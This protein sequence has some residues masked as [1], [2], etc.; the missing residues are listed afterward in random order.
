MSSPANL[1]RLF[2]VAAALAVV[3][4]VPRVA[5]AAPPP[6][7][8]GTAKP[9]PSACA[10]HLTRAADATISMVP[11]KAEYKQL[12]TAQPQ[13]TYSPLTPKVAVG[14]IGGCRRVA[15]DIVV[16]ST[17][18]SG[19]A[20]CYTFAEAHMGAADIPNG[21][22]FEEDFEVPKTSTAADVCKTFRHA[23]E[24]YQKLAG[25]TAFVKTSYRFD[26]RGR[27]ENGQ[28]R[29]YAYSPGT[30]QIHDTTEVFPGVNVPASGTNTYRI[31]SDLS[32][33]GVHVQPRI[34]VHFEPM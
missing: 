16:P 24:V 11:N 21:K 27:Y 2:R 13:V 26:Y 25:T 3:C 29:V 15:I 18:S 23:V 31:L 1:V 33:Q 22:T 28:C 34:V 6:A 32:Y 5:C 7:N 12:V 30:T 9:L 20:N 17:A 14:T 10:G 4:A 19:C 8:P